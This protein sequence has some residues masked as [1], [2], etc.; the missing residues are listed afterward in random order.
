M[1]FYPPAYD[2]HGALS[3]LAS[4]TKVRRDD[5]G[6]RPRAAGHKGGHDH[7]HRDCCGHGRPQPGDKL[8]RKRGKKEAEKTDAL[9]VGLRGL[10]L[11]PDDWLKR[12]TKYDP[13]RGGLVQF[14]G[15][16]LS[17]VSDLD[18]LGSR[19]GQ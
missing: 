19:I 7:A 6:Q 5:P 2:A 4:T 1:A 12:G 13:R 16:I 11:I 10:H 3:L 17:M 18:Y 8:G 15:G 14:G 9:K